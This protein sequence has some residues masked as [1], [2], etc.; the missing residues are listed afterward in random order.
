MGFIIYLNGAP[1]A[2]QSSLQSIPA[3]STAEPE[4]I[5]AATATR[6][7]RFLRNPLEEPHFKQEQPTILHEDNESTHSWITDPSK[8][9]RRN[10]HINKKFW[11]ARDAGAPRNGEIDCRK[12]ASKDQIAD[13]LTKNTTWEVHRELIGQVFLGV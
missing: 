12:I 13:L 10:M 4:L 3:D 9:T 2:W 11:I 8:L 6:T 1:I 7:N 5:A